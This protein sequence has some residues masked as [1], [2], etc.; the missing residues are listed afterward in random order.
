MI[1]VRVAHIITRLC[2]GG[3]QE[4]TFHTVRLANRNR[5]SVDLISGETFGQE[6]SIEDEVRAAGIDVIRVPHLVRQIAPFHDLRALWHL[7]RLLREGGYGIVHTHTSKAGF[8]GRLAAKRSGV[9]IIVHTPHGNIFEGYFPR[10]LTRFF[11]AMERR[12]A[13][14]T[15]RIIELTPGGIDEHLAQGIGRREQFVTIFSGID[16][17]PFTAAVARREATRRAL[18]IEQHEF[19]VGAVARLEPIKGLTYLV[20]AAQTVLDTLPNARFIV[21]GQG[22]LHS[23]L[24]TQA[25]RLGDRFRFLGPRDDVPDLMAAMDVFVLPSVNEGMGRVLLEAGA[26]GTPS[27]A[28]HVGGI[29]D[30]IEDG[31]TGILVPPRDPEALA[32]AIRTLAEDE[33]LRQAMGQAAQTS[34]VPE[35]GL[36]RMVARIEALYEELIEEKRYDR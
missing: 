6:G 9:P 14:W 27:V 35:Y 24:R 33:R 31:R 36:D 23:E 8:L 26:A 21:A 16:L 3:A 17:V 25:A 30:I 5:F 20:S 29:P 12:A 22:S 10:P 2:K 7:T 34:I 1:R 11:V 32:R 18:G 4:N 13:R 19:L 15:D 28:S